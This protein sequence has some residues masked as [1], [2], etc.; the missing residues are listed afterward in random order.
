MFAATRTNEGGGGFHGVVMEHKVIMNLT[1]ADGDKSLFRQWHQKFTTVLGQVG[2]AHVEIVH[3]LVK[4]IDLGKQLER[5]ATGLRDEFGDE[6]NRVSGD[7]WNILI[8]R[9]I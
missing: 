1:A 9:P 2:R 3:R 7:V 5:S 8:D 6:I 4:E